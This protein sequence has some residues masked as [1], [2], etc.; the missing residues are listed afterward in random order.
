MYDEGRGVP[1]N[2]VEAAYWFRRAAE[3]GDADAQFILGALYAEGQVLPQ[4]NGLAVHWYCKAAEQ[5]HVRAQYNLGLMYGDGRGVP[6][7][8]VQAHKWINLAA[9]RFS[10]SEWELRDAAVQLRNEV[11]AK[12]TSEQIAEA[13][14]LVREWKPGQ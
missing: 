8:Y 10:S 6:Q 1:Q 13:Q 4:M 9:A 2:D 14:R 7:D 12:M 5:G 11:A 3:Q